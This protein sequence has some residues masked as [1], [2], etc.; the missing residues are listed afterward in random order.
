MSLVPGESWLY[1]KDPTFK[2]KRRGRN[3]QSTLGIT[4]SCKKL[5]GQAQLPV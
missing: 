1:N 5:S 3:H 4:E 2:E